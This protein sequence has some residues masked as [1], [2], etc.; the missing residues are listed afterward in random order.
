MA[1]RATIDVIPILP[2]FKFRPNDAIDFNTGVS[3]TIEGSEG[4]VVLYE[5]SKIHD[6]RKESILNSTPTRMDFQ[7]ETQPS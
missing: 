2:R 3:S 6:Q 5:M 4:R 7:A 1:C